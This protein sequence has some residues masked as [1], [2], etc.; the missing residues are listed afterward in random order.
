MKNLVLLFMLGCV[1]CLT[2]FVQAQDSRFKRADQLYQQKDYIKA[3]EWYEFVLKKD[4]KEIP[5]HVFENLSDCY[6]SI[7]QYKKAESWM[8]RMAKREDCSEKSLFGYGHVLLINGKKERA[9]DVFL[10]IGEQGFVD[11]IDRAMKGEVLPSGW[12]AEY[13]KINSRY[14]EFG[15]SWYEEGFI[16]CSERNNSTMGVVH[17]SQ[18]TN[19]PLLNVYYTH[20]KNERKWTNP[21]PLGKKVNSKLHEGPSTLS[22]DGTHLFVNRSRKLKKSDRRDRKAG[23]PVE[24][25]IF[26][27][28]KDQWT[29]PKSA[30]FANQT[31]SYLHP[32]ISADGK[33]LFFASDLPGGKGGFDL[34]KVR[35]D[36]EKWGAPINLGP[37]IN[38]AYNEV[39]P[40][41]QPNGNLVFASNGH[42]GYGGLDLFEV[43]SM[44]DDWAMPFNLGTPINSQYDDFSMIVD[45]KKTTGYFASNRGRNPMDDNLYKA[46]REVPVFENCP[47]QE[48]PVM[49]YRFFEK[50]ME[51]DMPYQLIYEWDFGDGQTAPGIEARHCFDQPGVYEVTLRVIDSLSGGLMFNQASYQLKI[52]AP[53]QAYIEVN[54]DPEAGMTVVLDAAQTNL[55]GFVPEEY[56]WDFGD[57]A[58]GMGLQ[59]EHEYGV[60]GNYKVQLGMLGTMEGGTEKTTECVSRTIEVGVVPDLGDVKNLLKIKENLP[61][62][63]PNTDTTQPL[64]PKQNN[65]E[66]EAP[67]ETPPIKTTPHVTSPQT[68][69][70]P[71]TLS[72]D[73]QMQEKPV[74]ETTAK[75]AEE[76]K[77]VSP[78]P[79]LKENTPDPIVNNSPVNPRE[80]EKENAAPATYHGTS[81]PNRMPALD[82]NKVV[83]PFLEQPETVTVNGQLQFEGEPS[84]EGRIIWKNKDN[85]QV[86]K[87]THSI[88][89]SGAFS[90]QLPTGFRY[91]C[92]IDFPGYKVHLFP[93]DLRGYYGSDEID[94]RFKLVRVPR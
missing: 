69:Q 29:S 91:F 53:N 82:Q 68:V 41:I 32:S 76:E 12:K 33:W 72:E 80:E 31:A 52:G 34:Y 19:S 57:G 6:F 77:I 39:F 83:G 25:L 63:Q 85:G 90:L 45:A 44:G 59:V 42:P 65:P 93:L 50:G 62:E 74:E 16:F 48:E 56:F 54:T 22:P 7:R 28:K 47:V 92:E 11:H 3:I 14:T 88:S 35:I 84:W 67:E 20:P 13:M 21:A 75:A 64:K 49:C 81:A 79:P 30:D 73:S 37:Q 1:F 27:K 5:I 66:P 51:E 4:K 36:G 38:T 46:T 89:R 61:D 8:A 87:E 94:Q 86:I 15:P 43:T 58:T 40:Y 17:K 78:N 55:P 26:E 23:P 60:A 24:I 70:P 71:K 2:G 10:R 18:A 9:R